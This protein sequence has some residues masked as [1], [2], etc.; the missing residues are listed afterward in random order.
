MLNIW[1]SRNVAFSAPKVRKHNAVGKKIPN[2]GENILSYSAQELA[3]IT[4]TDF[5]TSYGVA[6]PISGDKTLTDN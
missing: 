5:F 6:T 1:N 2:L 4:D 3:F